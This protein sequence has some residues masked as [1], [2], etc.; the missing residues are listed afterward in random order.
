MHCGETTKH[1]CKHS[2]SKKNAINPSAPELNTRRE[3]PNTKI[4]TEGIIGHQTIADAWH[5]EQH[6]VYLTSGAKGLIVQVQCV[7]N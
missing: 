7:K 2:S 1:L 3:L 5:F 6:T 4:L